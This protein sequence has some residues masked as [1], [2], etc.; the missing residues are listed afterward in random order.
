MEPKTQTDGG[1]DKAGGV[2]IA[3]GTPDEWSNDIVEIGDAIANL[4]L[5][6][7][8]QLSTYLE[9]A[10]GIK[11]ATSG[12]VMPDQGPQPPK[13]EKPPEQTEFTVVLEGVPDATKKLGVVKLWREVTSQ[14][15]KESKDSVD[16]APKVLKENI[17]LAEANA[18]K[19]KFEA[20]GAKITIK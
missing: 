15:L 9:E 1:G 3:T 2:A 20:A 12:Y 17:P 4:T 19:E 18:L 14:G 6:Q 8:V 16:Q 5:A 7:A 11:P 10:H 13:E